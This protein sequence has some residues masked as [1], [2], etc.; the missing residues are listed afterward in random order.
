MDE[1]CFKKTINAAQRIIMNNIFS[2][3]LEEYL[4][5]EL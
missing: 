4:K 5:N 1:S 3:E 2:P